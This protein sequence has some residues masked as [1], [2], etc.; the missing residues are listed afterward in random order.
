MD[1]PAAWG[2]IPE[3][4]PLAGSPYT[5]ADDENTICATPFARS[6]SSIVIARPRFTSKYRCGFVT[7]SPTWILPAKCTTAAGEKRRHVSATV[8]ASPMSAMITA[9]SSGSDG[10]VPAEPSSSTTTRRPARVAIHT[11]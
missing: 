2:R 7:D 1:S 6:A 10:R 11:K 4:A 9:T 5:A 8:A 3:S